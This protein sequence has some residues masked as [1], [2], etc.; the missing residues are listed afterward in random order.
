MIFDL[1]LE[2]RN[3][4]IHSIDGTIICIP[5]DKIL[6]AGETPEVFSYVGRL[7]Q[8]ALSINSNKCG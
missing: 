1:Q 2:L 5:S 8:S 4:N 6:I 3:V 7:Y